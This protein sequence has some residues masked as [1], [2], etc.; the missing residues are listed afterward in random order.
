MNSEQLTELGA[1]H[2]VGALAGD[3]LREF[4]ELLGTATAS[5]RATV[6]ALHDTAA[7][8]AAAPAST[9]RPSAALK[10]RVL[11]EIARKKTPATVA[12]FYSIHRHEGVW[13]ES[14]MPGVRLKDLS[15]D[16]GR[17]VSVKLYELAPGAHFPAHHHSGPEQCFVLRGDFHVQGQVL[18]TGD[19]HHAAADSDHLESFS[20]GGCELLVMVAAGD[21][22]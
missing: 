14:G 19:F 21:Y 18:H 16:T 1:L 4:H 2:A 8:I 20:E 12:P 13:R 3:E 17:G 7:L 15:E 5:Q 10:A 11:A 9:Q 22:R 6:A